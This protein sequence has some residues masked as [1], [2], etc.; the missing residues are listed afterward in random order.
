MSSGKARPENAEVERRVKRRAQWLQ[1]NRWPASWVVP[2]LVT[3][4]ELHRGHNIDMS[5]YP[6]PTRPT[7]LQENLAEAYVSKPFTLPQ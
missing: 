3:V 7:L 6:Q 4:R 2:S 1:R 5:S